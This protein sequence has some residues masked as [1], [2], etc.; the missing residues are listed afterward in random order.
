MPRRCEAVP[1][2]PEESFFCKA[3]ISTPTPVLHYASGREMAIKSQKK[4]NNE[5]RQG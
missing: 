4:E 5:N 2:E 3:H 1:E